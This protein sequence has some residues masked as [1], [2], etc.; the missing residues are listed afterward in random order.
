CLWL[1]D[2]LPSQI[3]LAAG[4]VIPPFTGIASIVLVV[5]NVLSFGGM[6]VNAVH[7]DQMRDPRRGYTKAVMVAFGLILGV[8]VLPTIAVALVVPNAQ[9]GFTNGVNLAFG[10]YFGHLHI[11]W[12]TYV[13]SGAIALGAMASVISWVAGPSKGLAAAAST[14]L[15]PRW[16]QQRNE[17]GVQ[18]SSLAVQGV[19]VSLLALLFVFTPNVSNALIVLVDVAAALYLV[20][21]LLMFASVVVLRRKQPSAERVYRVKAVRLVAGTGFVASLAALIMAFVPPAGH[22]AFPPWAYPWLVG[23]AVVLLGSP[24]LLFYHFRK[25]AWVGPAADHSPPPVR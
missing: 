21:Y 14:G 20:M 23:L 11:D 13:L 5:S 3:P 4:D 6:E 1:A 25:P 24:P 18:E 10:A 16:L 8:T 17:H 15:L 9:L 2:G 12:A 22:S 7:A 19:I